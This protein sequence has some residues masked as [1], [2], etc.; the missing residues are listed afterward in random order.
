MDK[1]AGR[2]ELC[3][4]LSGDRPGEPVPHLVFVR[5]DGGAHTEDDELFERGVLRGLPRLAPHLI[6]AREHARVAVPAFAVLDGHASRDDRAV[7]LERLTHLAQRRGR[8]TELRLQIL[9][10][11]RTCTGE[12]PHQAR[13]VV[14]TGFRLRQRSTAERVGRASRLRREEQ[15]LAAVDLRLEHIRAFREL[16]APAP[17]RLR[18][19]RETLLRRVVRVLVC[20]GEQA[21][22][23]DVLRESQHPAVLKERMGVVERPQLPVRGEP[24]VEETLRAK[25]R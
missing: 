4:R 10:A 6:P 24:A 2:D 25:L 11:A 21:G 17:L 18:P 16:A 12:V 14:V 7:S 13:R 23:R 3:D 9:D 22:Q 8:E 19:R 20:R 15:R 1:P 5:Q